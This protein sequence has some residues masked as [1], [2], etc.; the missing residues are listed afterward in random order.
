MGDDFV[1]IDRNSKLVVSKAFG[2]DAFGDEWFSLQRGLTSLA[3]KPFSVRSTSKAQ[4][5]P[6]SSGPNAKSVT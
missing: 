1:A 2:D 3:A 4:C 5:C 6:L